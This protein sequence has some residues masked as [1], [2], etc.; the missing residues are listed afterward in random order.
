L[1]VAPHA[2]VWYWPAPQVAQEAH[3][4]LVVAPHAAA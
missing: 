3:V 4:V 1:V 2:A